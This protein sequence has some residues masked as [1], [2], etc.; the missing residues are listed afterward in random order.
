[1]FTNVH[2]PTAKSNGLEPYSIDPDTDFYTAGLLFNQL[3][4]D[5]QASRFRAGVAL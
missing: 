4:A 3:E 1:M 2:T 5:Y